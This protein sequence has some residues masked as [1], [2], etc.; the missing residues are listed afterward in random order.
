MSITPGDPLSAWTEAWREVELGGE[1]WQATIKARTRLSASADEFFLRAT[2]EVYEGET[3]V[4][5]REWD[6]AIPR[7]GV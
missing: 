2:L 6:E 5:K 4:F 7:N 3:R 1:G